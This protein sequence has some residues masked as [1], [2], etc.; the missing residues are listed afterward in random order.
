MDLN[1]GFQ[2]LDTSPRWSLRWPFIVV[3]LRDKWHSWTG[4]LYSSSPGMIWGRNAALV[5]PL[6]NRGRVLLSQ[7]HP[8]WLWPK[9]SLMLSSLDTSI[10]SWGQQAEAMEHCSHRHQLPGLLD[11]VGPCHSGD[12]DKCFLVLALRR[13]LEHSDGLILFYRLWRVGWSLCAEKWPLVPRLWV[14]NMVGITV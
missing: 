7:P 3:A 1:P 11:P 14:F 10:H 9:V 8:S 5:S 13:V 4:L 6:D 2:P 12:Q